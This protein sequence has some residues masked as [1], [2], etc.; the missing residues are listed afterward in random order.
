MSETIYYATCVCAC[1]KKP[2]K[3]T[4]LIGTC[5]ECIDSIKR[6]QEENEKLKAVAT[7]WAEVAVELKD[8]INLNRR[9]ELEKAIVGSLKSCIDAHGPITRLNVSSAAKRVIGTIKQWNKNE[10]NR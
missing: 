10:R 9:G 8:G 1:C 7:K 5:D 3:T 2:K 6:L 4:E